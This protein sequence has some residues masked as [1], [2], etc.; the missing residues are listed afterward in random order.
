MPDLPLIAAIDVGSNAFR[1][2]IASAGEDGKPDLLIRQR[3]PVRLGHDAFTSG[4]FSEATMDDAVAAF[5]SFRRLLDQHG[6][7]R[8]RAVATSAMRDAKNGRELI[9]RIARETDIRLEIISGEEEARLVQS[10]IARRVDLSGKFSLLI[11][12]GGGSVEI[13]LCDDGQVVTAQSLKLGTV[14]LLEMF[15]AEKSFNRL[16]GEYLEGMGRKLREMVGGGKAELCVATGGNASAIGDLG[17]KLLGTGSASQISRK[18]LRQLIKQLSKLSFEERVRDLGLRPDRADVILPAAMVIHEVMKLAEAAQLTMPDAGLLDGVLI[19][20][21]DNVELTSKSRRAHLV[22]W[23]KALKSKYHV[24]QQHAL[25]VA[26]LS[27]SLFDQ[28]LVLHRLELP[29]RLLLEIAALVHEIGM[30]ISVDGHH[31]HAAYMI[32]VTSL[33]GLSEDERKLLSRIVRYQRKGLPTTDHKDAADLSDAERN[34]VWQLSALLRM[35]IALDKERRSRV[36]S[37]HAVVHDDRVELLVE[38]QG[39]LLLERWAAIK[40]ADYFEKAFGLPLKVDLATS[41]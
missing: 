17:Q 39:D 14:R 40:T 29:D 20:M 25:T 12:I 21:L 4:R 41:E 10:S 3:E 5:G 31:R 22:S 37:I 24:D 15:G 13:T 2:G 9:Q 34:K 1:L 8:L 38:G 23:A 27:L 30:Y 6:T 16:L 28:T 7:P 19:D 36:E 18:E 32:A 35:G 11:D 26:R 33:V